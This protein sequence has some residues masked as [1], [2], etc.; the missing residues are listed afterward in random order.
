[1]RNVWYVLGLVGQ[2]GFIIAIPV[3]ILA[4]IGA[5]LDKIYSTSPFFLLAGIGLSI[6]VSSLI[7]YRKI[8]QL[9][10]K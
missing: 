7:I 8:K 3:A 10:N 9:E 4:Y 6:F 5:K 2:I 1:M